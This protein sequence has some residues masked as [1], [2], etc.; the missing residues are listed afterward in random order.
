MAG[1]IVRRSLSSFLVVVLTSMFVFALFFL[2]PSNPAGP[3]CEALGRCTAE[4]LEL[5]EQQMGLD[6]SVVTQYGAFVGGLLLAS[7]RSLG[8]AVAGVGISGGLVGVIYAL[9]WL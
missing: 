9:G 5:I 2:G 4:R 7:R 6:Q 1:F 3:V 8:L